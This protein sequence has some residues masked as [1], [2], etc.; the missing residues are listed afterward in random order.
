M[1]CH[2]VQCNTENRTAV[3]LIC[4]ALHSSV[5]DMQ[6]GRV[7]EAFIEGDAREERVLDGCGVR[8]S[9]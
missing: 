4:T 1:W 7:V 3:K 5:I 8:M 6:R 9:N 2:T